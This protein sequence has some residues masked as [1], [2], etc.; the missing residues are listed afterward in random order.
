[1]P[2]FDINVYKDEAWKLC[3][4]TLVATPNGWGTGVEMFK[5]TLVLT[6]EEAVQL[7]LEGTNIWEEDDW[8]EKDTLVREFGLSDRILEWVQKVEEVIDKRLAH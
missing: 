3:P 7:G 8:I 6:D 4:Y 5:H 2:N 1:M